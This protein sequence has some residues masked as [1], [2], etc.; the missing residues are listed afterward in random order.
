MECFKLSE[1]F[2]RRLEEKHGESNTDDGCLTCAF[3]KE[4][5]TLPGLCNQSVV[6]GNWG[7][8]NHLCLTG[9][10]KHYGKIFV[11]WDN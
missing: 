6:S 5:K 11:S 3:Q 2:Y 1:L 10:Q 9:D 8:K 7:L 4:A